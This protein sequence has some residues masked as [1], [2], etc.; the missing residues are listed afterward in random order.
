MS[1][2]AFFQTVLCGIG[3]VV[4]A[5]G[6]GY[7]CIFHWPDVYQRSEQAN[8]EKAYQ[9]GFS[10]GYNGGDVHDRR[11][12]KWDSQLMEWNKGFYEGVAKRKNEEKQ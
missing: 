1:V 10:A 9:Y 12:L 4:V 5:A 6:L 7:L 2:K 11:F 3:A 8:R